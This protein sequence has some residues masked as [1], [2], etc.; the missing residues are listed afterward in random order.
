MDAALQ[1]SEKIVVISREDMQPVI[2]HDLSVHP[3]K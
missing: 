1:D 2:W 3:N